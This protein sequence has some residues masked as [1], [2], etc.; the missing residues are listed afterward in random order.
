MRYWAIEKNYVMVWPWPTAAQR[1][2]FLYFRKPALVNSG[3]TLDFDATQILLLRRVLD[4]HVAQRGPCTAGTVQ[5]CKKTMDDAISVAF[6]WDKTTTNV[7]LTLGIND[8]HPDWLT[9]Q[10]VP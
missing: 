7:G 6:T 10:I 4:Y 8:L 3:D 2:N 5:E 1:V 9:G